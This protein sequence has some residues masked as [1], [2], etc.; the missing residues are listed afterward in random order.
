MKNWCISWQGGGHMDS[1]YLEN[2][3]RKRGNRCEWLFIERHFSSWKKWFYLMYSGIEICCSTRYVI[4][5]NRQGGERGK[6][7]RR[8]VFGI[9]QRADEPFGMIKKIERQVG[10]V[11]LVKRFYWYVPSSKLHDIYTP[12][13]LDIEFVKS[14]CITCIS[15]HFH[16]YADVWIVLN[17][18]WMKWSMVFCQRGARWGRL[19]WV[20]ECGKS[21]VLE[22]V[23]AGQAKGWSEAIWIE[24]QAKAG[25]CNVELGLSLV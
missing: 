5:N 21:W 12:T 18:I 20:E 16:R 8:D 11:L 1:I 24:G 4:H 9:C 23:R 6:A 7:H 13:L 25:G 2:Y 10:K 19:P 3:T 22:K 15:F 14:V 17:G